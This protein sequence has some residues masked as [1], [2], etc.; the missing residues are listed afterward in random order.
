MKGA[1]IFKYPFSYIIFTAISFG[2]GVAFA[3]YF[4]NT[5]YIKIV[6]CFTFLFLIILIFSLIFIKNIYTCIF[7]F[8]ICV[9]LSAYLYTNVRYYKIFNT[10]LSNI[11]YTIKAF[12]GN[13]T[14][15][16]GRILNRERF[17]V[18]IY[19]VYDGTNWYD[20]SGEIRLYNNTSK[21]IEVG[22]F[23]TVNSRLNLYKDIFEFYEN[24]SD[25][26]SS[27][28]AN[29]AIVK[30]LEN[31]MLFGVSTIYR[32]QNV[33]VYK[34]FSLQGII[35]SFMLPLRDF[36]K[37]SISKNIEGD[38]YSVIASIFL[39]DRLIANYDIQSIFRDA[40]ISHLLVVSGIHISIFIFIAFFVLTLFNI[41]FYKKII[42]S[43]ILALCYLPITLYLVSAVRSVVMV[44]TFLLVLLFDRKKNLIN[45]LFL[46][47][48]IILIVSP[49]SL[50]D[51]SFQFSFLATLSIILYFPV[52]KTI[53]LSSFNKMPQKK[54]AMQIMIIYFLESFFI[55]FS[56]VIIT[57][58]LS[59]HYFSV[60][61]IASLITNLYALPLSFLIIV[62]SFIVVITDCIFPFLSIYPSA[63]LE[64][65]TNILI[66]INSKFASVK[67][68][69][70]NIICSMSVAVI[71]TFF[72]IAI[73]FFAY[74]KI[75]LV[76]SK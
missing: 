10:K 24:Q 64:F 69:R 55:T 68:L 44:L 40:G 75:V 27:N 70:F 36:I 16:D 48:L 56:A 28:D 58:P 43:S 59:V 25:N 72:I 1:T 71:I 74:F 18:L 7:L 2:F 13:V 49:S 19:S 54:N 26:N 29:N 30:S 52:F 67:Y 45:A 63:T 73:G 65:I 32:S 33:V 23:I 41:N 62:T 14:G 51:I 42:F 11:N 46:S 34:G 15:Y 20:A 76:K 38:T 17:R 66:H 5:Q 3:F 39:G 57:L 31:K 60:L 6:F 8:L 50:K 53:F 12:S 61:N 37:Q 47:V 9:C 21:K 22:D 35:Y 4:E